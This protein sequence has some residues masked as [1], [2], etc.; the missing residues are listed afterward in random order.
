MLVCLGYVKADP[1]VLLERLAHDVVGRPV[2]VVVALLG[3][4]LLVGPGVVADYPVKLNLFESLGKGLKP[5]RA[6]DPQLHRCLGKRDFVGC[7]E[8]CGDVP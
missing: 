5:L 4:W 6:V 2:G 3:P 7:L 1:R 8:L